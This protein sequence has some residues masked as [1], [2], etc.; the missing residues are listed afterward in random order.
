MAW[1]SISHRLSIRPRIFGGFGLLIAVFLVAVAISLTGQAHV[2]QEADA[3]S[4]S[5]LVAE[6][7]ADFVAKAVE[8]QKSVLRYAVSENDADLAETQKALSEFAEGAHVLKATSVDWKSG[9]SAVSSALEAGLKYQ[10]ASADTIQI[11]AGRREAASQ[12]T[13]KSLRYAPSAR[14]SQRRSYA[15][16][17]RPRP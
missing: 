1:T 8:T 11:I 13:T 17:R 9:V 4:S 6:H 10:A 3:V 16:T 5:S 14:R 2:D 12:F 15:K 7:V